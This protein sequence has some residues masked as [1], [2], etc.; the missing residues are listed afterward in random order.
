[1][2]VCVFPETATFSGDILHKIMLCVCC[3]FWILLY[4]HTWSFIWL[5]CCNSV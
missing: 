2:C 3:L 1:V 4:H 5:A